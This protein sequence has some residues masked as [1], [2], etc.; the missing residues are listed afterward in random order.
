MVNRRNR[1]LGVL[2]PAL[3]TALVVTGCAGDTAEPAIAP[4]AAASPSAVATSAVPGAGVPSAGAPASGVPTAAGSETATGTITAGVE[5]NCLI[6]KGDGD[7]RLLV[8]DDPALKAAAKVGAKV[9]VVGRAEPGLVTTCQQGTP[10]I[11]T[12]LRSS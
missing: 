9:T 11:V 5:A 3:V 12:S 4:E 7:P 1:I 2:L 6:L 8:F 10:F